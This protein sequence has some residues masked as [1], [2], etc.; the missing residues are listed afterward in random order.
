MNIV[1]DMVIFDD[2]FIYDDNDAFIYEKYM[3]LSFIRT[4]IFVVWS[5][6]SIRIYFL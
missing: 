6:M 1:F 5:S 4:Y 3:A 2:F